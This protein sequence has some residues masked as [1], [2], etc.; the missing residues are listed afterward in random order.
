MLAEYDGPD[1]LAARIGGDE[2]CLLLEGA[3]AA[4]GQR[5]VEE[6]TRRLGTAE[7][8]LDVSWGLAVHDGGCTT[9]LLR[10][11]DAA[12]YAAKRR[13]GWDARGPTGRRVAHEPESAA[14]LLGEAQ[15]L[16][17]GVR[18][19]PEQLRAAVAA[20]GAALYPPDA[21]GAAAAT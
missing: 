5:V 3:S 17:D 18:G 12:Q 6:L 20:L 16:L 21:L 4:D 1:A 2:F 19:D 13:R 15:A 9:E 8:P 7:P 11:A 10:A 14:A